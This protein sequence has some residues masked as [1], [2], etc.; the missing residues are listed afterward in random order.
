MEEG[1]GEREKQQQ[2]RR[3]EGVLFML[4][5]SCFYLRGGGICHFFILQSIHVAVKCTP[6]ILHHYRKTHFQANG[7]LTRSGKKSH[8][9]AKC[10]SCRCCYFSKSIVRQ[11][12]VGKKI[13]QSSLLHRDVKMKIYHRNQPRCAGLYLSHRSHADR[14]RNY[15]TA[16]PYMEQGISLRPSEQRKPK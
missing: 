15:R 7:N 6:M 8:T 11:T 10:S 3:W 4:C 16:N 2:G 1:Y 13:G 12:S 14:L 9:L 5:M